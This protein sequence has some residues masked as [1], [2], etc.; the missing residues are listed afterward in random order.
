MDTRTTEPRVEFPRPAPPLSRPGHR[1]AVVGRAGGTDASSGEPAVELVPRESAPALRV[2]GPGRRERA[3]LRQ[4]SELGAELHALDA[5]QSEAA[6]E[7]RV[8][9]LV[10]RG[11]GRWMDRMD[12]ELERSRQ[13]GNRLLVALGASQRE[14]AQLREELAA[15]RARIRSLAP[16]PPVRRPARWRRL[17]GLG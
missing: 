11:A 2:V 15:A 17:L 8:A 1:G 6:R 3:Y 9:R 14:T 4:I 16:A 7:L 13:Q 12:R 10:E 5:A